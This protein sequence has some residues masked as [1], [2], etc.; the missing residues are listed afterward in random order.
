M[1]HTAL[2]WRGGWRQIPAFVALRLPPVRIY[3]ED[4]GRPGDVGLVA[5][6]NGEPVGLVW[7]RLFTEKVHGEGY[8]DPE[9]PELAIAVKKRHRG[10]GVGRALMEAA[11]DRAR[12]DGIRRMSLSVSEGNPA[13]RLYRSL[14]YVDYEP[15]DTLGRMILELGPVERTGAG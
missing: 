1:L 15:G 11:H 10:R 2:F 14:G 7:Y 13:K 8:V 6:R 9:T 4:W 3:H 5:E 12:R